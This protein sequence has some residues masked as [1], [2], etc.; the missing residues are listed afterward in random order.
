[1]AEGHLEGEWQGVGSPFRTGS[2]PSPNEKPA[3]L[4]SSERGSIMEGV[5]ESAFSDL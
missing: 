2:P 5:L 4:G 1:M 3:P